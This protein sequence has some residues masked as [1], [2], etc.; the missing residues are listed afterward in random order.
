MSARTPT[1]TR[2]LDDAT[3]RRPD[4]SLNVKEY[5]LFAVMGMGVL[6]P[7]NAIITAI[8]Y[9]EDIYPDVGIELY[10]SVAYTWSLLI[11][12]A[13][14]LALKSL[15]T[16]EKLMAAGYVIMLAVLFLFLVMRSPPLLLSIVFAVLVGAGDAIAQ[17]GL[18][19]YA[20]MRSPAHT[21]AVMAGN[22]S[23]GLIVAVLRLLTKW[24]L[25]NAEDPLYASSRVYF[26]ICNLVICMAL[27]ALYVKQRSERGKGGCFGLPCE[28]SKEKKRDTFVE[29]RN[30]TPHSVEEA[31]VTSENSDEKNADDD[32]VALVD[33]HDPRTS[34][35]SSMVKESVVLVHKEWGVFLARAFARV[36]A[37]CRIA[38]Q[39]L[40]AMFCVFFVTLSLFPGIIV[41]IE[42]DDGLGDWL[43]IVLIAVFN[44]WDTIG[45]CSLSVASVRSWVENVVLIR[46]SVSLTVPCLV[47]A[48]FYPL[49]CLAVRPGWGSDLVVVVIVSAFGLSNGFLATSSIVVGPQL[50]K[51]LE[52][53]GLVSVLLVFALMIGLAFGAATGVGLDALV[54]G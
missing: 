12:M 23:A 53:K 31:G 37:A 11:V 40:L 25:A 41:E 44:L 18:F 26:A 34:S 3:E 17:S 33:K 49:I 38:W 43:P 20:A 4:A 19:A 54:S 10:F 35:S 42:S 27:L 13:I 52:E 21:G 48:V 30:L 5:C 45:R 51:G 2:S 50:V 24:S 15:T 47:R 46:K 29:L 1:N 28:G 14:A 22:G 32:G 36:V 6:F 7:W 8:D 16:D 9:F 39:P